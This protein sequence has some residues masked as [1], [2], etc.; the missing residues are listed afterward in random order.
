MYFDSWRWR[1]RMFK[2]KCD[3][4][5]MRIFHFIFRTVWTKQMTIWSI[6]CGYAIGCN[7]MALCLNRIGCYLCLMQVEYFIIYDITHK[8]ILACWWSAYFHMG[9]NDTWFRAC[10][11]TLCENQWHRKDGS[12]STASLHQT[13]SRMYYDLALWEFSLTSHGI[14]KRGLFGKILLPL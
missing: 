7:E 13:V 9:S 2:P 11:D 1:P 3:H 8:Y 10:I 12:T 5:A 4:G 6:E 14:L